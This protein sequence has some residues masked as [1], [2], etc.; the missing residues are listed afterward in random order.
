MAMIVGCTY[1]IVQQFEGVT[2]HNA[3]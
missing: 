2:I 3:A 1:C